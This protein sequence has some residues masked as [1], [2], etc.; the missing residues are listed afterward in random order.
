MFKMSFGVSQQ[1]YEEWVMCQAPGKKLIFAFSDWYPT[2]VGEEPDLFYL[3][4]VSCKKRLLDSQVLLSEAVGEFTRLLLSFSPP[5]DD[6][7]FFFFLLSFSKLHLQRE[8]SKCRGCL[9]QNCEE[10]S[11]APFISTDFWYK[12]W[13]SE[14]K[15]L[16]YLILLKHVLECHWSTCLF[17]QLCAFGAGVV[18]QGCFT[19]QNLCK[20]SQLNTEVF[21]PLLWKHPSCW[22]Q[23]CANWA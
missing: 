8:P 23:R 1:A 21:L 12:A 20:K 22:N 11:A 2:V 15:A 7:C 5:S 17:V 6:F 10:V 14:S 3:N 16:K 4:W 19:A 13:I 9:Y 18:D